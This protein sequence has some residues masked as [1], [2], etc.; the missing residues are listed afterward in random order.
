MSE[1]ASQPVTVSSPPRDEPALL[2]RALVEDRHRLRIP[3][4]V[5]WIEQTVLYLAGRAQVM[6][7]CDADRRKKLVTAL[8]EAITNAIVHG[9]LEITSGLKEDSS[10]AFA[11]TLAERSS[12][13]AYAQREVDIVV[14][15]DGTACRWTITDEG[16]GFDVP[17]MLRKLDEPP[18]PEADPMALL[19]SG[20]GIMLM[21]AFLDDVQWFD[22]GRRVE[23]TLHRDEVGER[24]AA[25]RLP[26]I[27]PVRAVPVGEDGAIDWQAAFDAVATNVSRG[28]MG[29]IAPDLGKARRLVLELAVEGQT[30]Y[31]PAEVMN[32][33][34]VD[35][36][37]VQ[38][39][40]RVAPPSASAQ[41]PD[42]QGSDQQQAALDR[43]FER[44]SDQGVVD[45]ERREHSRM[46]Y[47]RPVQLIT[48]DRHLAGVAR[49]LSKSGIAV[50]GEFD[51]A[52]GEPITVILDSDGDEPIRLWGQVVRC[53]RVA[54][55]FHDIGIRFLD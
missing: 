32:L 34:R 33:R 37:V 9:N 26:A 3:S 16:R 5:D 36:Q 6:G 45:D 7:A 12:D 47:T 30:V 15:Y 53:H 42:A 10:G 31:V 41:T 28:G 13:P 40:C 8:T 39:G 52:R 43:V 21:R 18:D 20:R 29:M 50:V 48:G 25:P 46:A 19:A 54:G 17:A 55:H 27:E 23:L 1:A 22:G 49:D 11:K 51:L 35:E 44:L 2:R 14:D 38:I 4:R 24:R